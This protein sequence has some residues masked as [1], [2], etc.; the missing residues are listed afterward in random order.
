MLSEN[1][2]LPMIQEASSIL[3]QLIMMNPILIYFQYNQTLFYFKR[4]ELNVKFLKNPIEN[5][6]EFQDIK[7]P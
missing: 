5:G 7:N 2:Q 1:F 6:E 4:F 3:A